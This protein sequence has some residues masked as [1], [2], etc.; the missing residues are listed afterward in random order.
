[1]CL[2][3]RL[4][5]CADKYYRNGYGNYRA[6]C[7]GFVSMSWNLDS[8]L[9]T[10][11]LPGVARRIGKSDLK[12]GDILN[13]SGRHV[14]LFHKWAN[15]SK[16]A[17]RGYEQTPPRAVYRKIPYPYFD[18]GDGYAPYRYRNIVDGPTT[19][20]NDKSV[21]GDSYA[22]LVAVDGKVMWLYPAK[23]SGRYGKRVRIGGGWRDNYHRI[24]LGDANADGHAD[25]FATATDGTLF[26]WQNRGDGR[27][28]K[29]RQVGHGWKTKR[30][31]AVADA[32]GDGRADLFGV[33]GD[34]L[35]LYVGKGDGT[36][37]RPALVDRGW[38]RFNRV[39]AG[40]ADRDGRAD[41]FAT[42]RAG[43]LWYAKNSDDGWGGHGVS[44]PSVRRVGAGWDVH[45][46][47]VAADVTGDRRTD[48]V[49]VRRDGTL[50]LYP[51][52]GNGGFGKARRVGHGWSGLRLATY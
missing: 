24:A 11:S 38:A 7:S 52:A 9:T 26:Y 13:R 19:V 30:W 2:G 49:A 33:H 47:V 44:F 12:A 5:D 36:F 8:S 4:K 37:G 29:R 17:Y 1:Y 32:N 23:A 39:V 15:S 25:I 46:Q 51:G 16:T 40:D 34:K 42:D 28:A 14:V 20:P 50:W 41:L 35:L 3:H 18:G 43:R 10:R 27:Y 22:D 6:D 31:F 21:N 48:L 45:R